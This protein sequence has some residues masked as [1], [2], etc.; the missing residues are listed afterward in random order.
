MRQGLN[1]MSLTPFLGWEYPVFSLGLVLPQSIPMPSL[2]G[3]P[4]LRAPHS[5]E[6]MLEWARGWRGREQNPHLSRSSYRPVIY[7]EHNVKWSGFKL[8][9][10]ILGKTFKLSVSMSSSVKWEEWQY[11]PMVLLWGYKCRVLRIRYDTHKRYINICCNLKYYF[12]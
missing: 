7:L 1:E 4:L 11:L 6:S 5:L 12:P 8:S 9:C 2:C 3:V 10:V